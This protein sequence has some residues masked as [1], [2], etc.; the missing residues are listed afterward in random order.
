MVTSDEA[1]IRYFTIVGETAK[2]QIGIG[3]DA[4]D[5]IGLVQAGIELTVTNGRVGIGTTTPEGTLDV[6]GD[7]APEIQ[8][9]TSPRPTTII[10][11][12][13]TRRDSRRSRIRPTLM[14]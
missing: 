12:S 9:S 4:D 3:N 1:F 13:A 6:K 11:R 2:L 7:I 5:S 14:V 8:T 10:P